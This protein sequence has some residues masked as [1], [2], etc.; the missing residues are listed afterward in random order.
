MVAERLQAVVLQIKP[1]HESHRLVDL[2]TRERGVIRIV[3]HGAQKP[4]HPLFSILQPLS[5]CQLQVR[6]GVSG[7]GTVDQGR[8]LRVFA[9]LQEDPVRLAYG[10]AI[11]EL[12][13]RVAGVEDASRIGMKA[14]YTDLLLSCERLANGFAPGI[15]FSAMLISALPLAGLGLDMQSC[16]ACGSLGNSLE[17]FSLARS[18]GICAVCAATTEERLAWP[19][20]PRSRHVLSQLSKTPWKNIRSVNVS[21]ATER[22]VVR[23]LTALL[24]EQAGVEL[25]SVRIAEQLDVRYTASE[26]VNRQH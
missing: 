4:Q 7:M 9:T 14:L 1:F 18:G 11:A 23:L 16:A 5:E 22:E 10:I 12:I 15:V 26:G 3:A 25:R 8:S 24:E 17:W 21:V 6:S 20:S 13:L 2:L 19:L